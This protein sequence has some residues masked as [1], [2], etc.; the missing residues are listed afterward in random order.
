MK[1]IYVICPVRLANDEIRKRLE[2]Y[3]GMLEAL[4]HRVFLPHRDNEFEHGDCGMDI[5]LSNAKAMREADEV[6]LLYDAMSQG[7]H[8]DMGFCFALDKPLKL[9]EPVDESL[10]DGFEWM[11]ARWAERVP[12]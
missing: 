8:F 9:V 2:G 5:C 11:A 4:G 10:R 3:A 7:I 1:S 12:E 6:H